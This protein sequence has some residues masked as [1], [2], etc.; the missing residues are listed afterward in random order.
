[1]T[2]EYTS[3]P[4]TSALTTAFGG[5][6]LTSYLFRGRPAW[7]A[8]DV[9]AALGYDPG[10]FRACLGT[11]AE[12]L[13]DGQDIETIRGEDL[14]EFKG[15][16][17]ASVGSTLG[18]ASHLTILYESGMHVACLKTEKPLG[19][20]LRRHLADEVLPKLIRR[21]PILP[22]PSSV[23]AVASEWSPEALVLRKAALLQQI[24]NDMSPAV[25]AEARDAIRA[26]AASML[27]GARLAPML[28]VMPEGKW[29][30]ATEM[31]KAIGVTTQALALAITALG[32]RGTA[33]MKTIMDQKKGSEGQ[34]VAYLW[35]DH[36][37]D[38]LTA[39]FASKAEAT[40]AK[41]PV[42]AKQRG[43]SGAL[44]Q[45]ATGAAS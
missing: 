16:L 3:Q 19:R 23:P 29:H 36:V 17:D 32:F 14:R 21:E 4:Q 44:F 35:D 30:R 26:N 41:P 25:S 22:A 1:M 13:L 20:V 7:I 27:T 10:G 15:L 37:F 40:P 42:K 8:A 31:A 38:A 43:G 2:T 6:S 18:R 39:H 33:H 28:P 45:A 5:G 11:W 9:G 12:E 24:A 34:T